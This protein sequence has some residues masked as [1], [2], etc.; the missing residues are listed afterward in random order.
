MALDWASEN[1]EHLANDTGR[2]ISSPVSKKIHFKFV[3]NIIYKINILLCWAALLG[4]NEDKP[5]HASKS[6]GSTG[7]WHS[8]MEVYVPVTAIIPT[9]NDL[10]FCYV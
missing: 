7:M 8:G 5:G 9:S 4:V 10:A 1:K 3:L 2:N 6:Y